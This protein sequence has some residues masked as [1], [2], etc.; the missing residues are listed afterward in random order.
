MYGDVG[1]SSAG[2]AFTIKCALYE[3]GLLSSPH[4]VICIVTIHIL[5]HC[6]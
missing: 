1:N 6:S 2:F 4:S 3:L 5:Y